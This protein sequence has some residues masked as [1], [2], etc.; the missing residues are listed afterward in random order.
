MV[1]SALRE[2]EPDESKGS[3]PVLRGQRRGNPP[4]LPD[5]TQF[6]AV[7]HREIY[8][9]ESDTDGKNYFLI[10][11]LECSPRRAEIIA[12]KIKKLKIE[13][14]Y[15]YE[16]KWTNIGNNDRFIG[17]Y[18]ALID[19]YLNDK[20]LHF[21]LIKFNKNKDWKKWVNSEEQRFF[22]CYYYFLQSI[23]HPFKRYSVFLD[24]MELSKKYSWDS[25][26]WALLNSFRAKEPEYLYNNKK[27]ITLL[28]SVDSK[29]MAMIQLTDVLIKATYNDSQSIG[30]KQVS[31]YLIKNMRHQIE[32]W[33][34]DI[35]KTKKYKEKMPKR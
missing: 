35:T 20:F 10:G 13:A 18:K 29:E 22:R 33:D 26:Y 23:M 5:N 30:K 25:L 16:F 6:M 32:E 15:P 1:Y 17:I 12:D 19:I 3:S 34:F 2:L 21:Y 24:K 7:E 11:G 8:C 4:E 14:N 9:D 31:D 27:N 28:S